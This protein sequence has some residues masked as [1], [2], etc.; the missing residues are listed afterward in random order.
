MVLVKNWQFSIFLISAKQARK[1][2]L[3][4]FQHEKKPF[5]TIKTRILKS[6]NLGF[7]QRGQ[8]TV[9]V[10]QNTYLLTRSDSTNMHLPLCLRI[11][12]EWWT[13]APQKTSCMKSLQWARHFFSHPLS[14]KESA[15]G[16]RWQR[17]SIRRQE[18]QRSSFSSPLYV[19]VVLLP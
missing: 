7:F 14:Q 13:S 11:P 18:R 15:K 6:G 2:S 1:I 8:S 3:R 12:A 5:K 16:T 9:L 10:K 17:R 19:Q 4:I